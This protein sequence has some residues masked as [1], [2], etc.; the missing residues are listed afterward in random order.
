MTLTSIRRSPTPS[1]GLW[2]IE[3]RT[4]EESEDLSGLAGVKPLYRTGDEPLE[5]QQEAYHK[6]LLGI[7]KE[8]PNPNLVPF[9]PARPFDPW[10]EWE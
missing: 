9:P 1:I 4:G 8:Q 6:A 3:P 5:D 2:L 7:G 10:H